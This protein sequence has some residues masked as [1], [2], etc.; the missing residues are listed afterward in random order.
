MGILTPILYAYIVLLATTISIL[1]THAL[2][3]RL[4][5]RHSERV[6]SLLSR[7]YM[8]ITMAIMLSNESL[9]TRFPMLKRRGACEL[10]AQTL[11]TVSTSVYGPDVAMLGRIATDNGIDR[12]LLRKAR[13][14]RGFARAHYIS[15]LAAI[16]LSHQAA[17]E[18]LRYADDSNPFVRFYA[19]AIRIC[20]DTSSALRELAEYPHTLNH[21]ETS[22]IMAILR[23]GM[24]PVA[25]EPLL[26]ST[27][28]NLRLIG[29]RIAGEF[30]IK[31][32]QP[33][34]LALAAEESD[35]EVMQEA[36]YTLIAQHSSLAHSEIAGSIRRL[37]AS[38]R[39]SLCRHLAFEGY[40]ANALERLFGS[41]DGSYAQRLVATYKR[42]IVCIP[43]L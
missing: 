18:A 36:I 25:C 30:G 21:F 39:R 22:E 9:P 1:V 37:L 4:R 23:R 24:L 38:E 10:L 41:S 35:D 29:L 6:S 28:R 13:R 8:R 43:Q 40:S 42:R 34:L 14:S 5:R 26:V 15:L 7:R 27:N 16:P 11:A 33:L 19:L 20:N 31:E 3:N 2:F 12:Y 17:A 32:A